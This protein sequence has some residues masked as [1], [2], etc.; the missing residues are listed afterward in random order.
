MRRDAL[1]RLDREGCFGGC[2][3]QQVVDH[4]LVLIGNVGDPCRQSVDDMEVLNR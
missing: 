4:P 2:L 3:E 1:D